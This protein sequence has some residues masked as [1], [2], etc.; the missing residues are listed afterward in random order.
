MSEF[1]A[2]ADHSRATS[3][4]SASPQNRLQRRVGKMSGFNTRSRLMNTAIEG[5]EN[6]KVSLERRMKSDG[7]RRLFSVG[8]Q[9]HAP[10]SQA[11]NMSKTDRSNVRSNV[12]ENRSSGVKS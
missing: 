3:A 7:L 10:F 11:A 9:T 2:A 12:C 6:Q 5:T 4:G 8:Q 1:G